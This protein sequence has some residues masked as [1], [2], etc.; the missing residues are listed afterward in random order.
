MKKSVIAVVSGLIGGATTA[1]LIKN[2]AKDAIEEKSNKADK[3][4]SYY[5]ML[6]QWLCIKQKNCNLAEYFKKNNYNRI[7]IYGLGE[8]GNR[9][10]EELKGTEVEVIYGMDKDIDGILCDITAYSLDDV[11]QVLEK[12]DVVVVT[13]IF[14][15]DEIKDKLSQKL[16]AEIVSLEDVVFEVY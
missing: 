12:P 2:I 1:A 13:A 5:T 7:A 10:I 8:M 16:E 6:N 4:K 15:Y 14:A 11:E 3:F 9:L